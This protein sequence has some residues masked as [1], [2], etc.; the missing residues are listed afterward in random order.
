VTSGR[1]RALVIHHDAGSTLG[2]LGDLLAER[3]V[4]VREHLVCGEAGSPLATGPLPG[5]DGADLVVALGS[6]WSV[7]DEASIGGW[8]GDE[9]ALLR[10]AHEAGVGVLGICFGGQALAAALGGTVRP[11]P[12]PDIGWSTIDSDVAAI[13][14][15]PWFQWHLDVFTVPPGADELARS[16]SGPQAFRRG[17]SLGLQ[18]HPELDPEL[19]A[20]WTLADRQELVDAGIDPDRL[21]AETVGRSQLARPHTA[22]LLDW[23]LDEVLP[24]PG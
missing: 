10:T 24:S 7:Y 16:A 5:L 6:R 9:L 22:A 13:A 23:Y 11:G 8:I 20:R 15:G 3:D 19:L 21:A 4:G 18:F 2:L 12:S 1:R 14:E 17:R